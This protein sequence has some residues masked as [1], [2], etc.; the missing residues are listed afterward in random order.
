MTTT[1]SKRYRCNHAYIDGANLHKGAESLGWQI[2]YKKFYVWL[3]DKYRIKR[4]YIFMGYRPGFGKMY[5]RMRE[6]G[7]LVRFKEVIVTPDGKIKGNCDTDM[8]V[9][10]VQDVYESVFDQAII[11]SSDGDFYSLVEYL[12]GKD[13]M[14]SVLSPYNNCSTLLMKIGVPIAYLNDFRDLVSFI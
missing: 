9:R 7:F 13:K 2:D 1:A 3:K 11:V 12:K 5:A 4:A 10:S 6:A 14:A 8:A